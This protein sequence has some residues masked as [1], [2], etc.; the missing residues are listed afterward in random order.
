MD[1]RSICVLRSVIL[2]FGLYLNSEHG[3]CMLCNILIQYVK[4]DL[5]TANAQYDVV[6]IMKGLVV[7]Y[8]SQ[9]FFVYGVDF[10]YEMIIKTFLLA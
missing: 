4:S 2:I 3:K 9:C 8:L 1:W 5:W 6:R 7:T 10:L